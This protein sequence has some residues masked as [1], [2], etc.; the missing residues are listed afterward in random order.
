M[1]GP[2]MAPRTNQ[3]P[4]ETPSQRLERLARLIDE[5]SDQM[6]TTVLEIREEQTDAQET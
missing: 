5:L 4:E 6:L 2:A 1:K 3:P